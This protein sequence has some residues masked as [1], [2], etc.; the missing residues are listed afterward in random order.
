MKN[1]E[2]KESRKRR[3]ERKN[4]GKDVDT[5]LANSQ[6]RESSLKALFE[7]GFNCGGKEESERRGSRSSPGLLGES[8][9]WKRG[10]EPESTTRAFNYPYINNK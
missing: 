10:S 9:D 7:R 4:G 3:R 6:L 8:D 1:K 2:K 5:F